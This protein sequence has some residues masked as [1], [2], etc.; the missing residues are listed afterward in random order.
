MFK[1]LLI[2]IVALAVLGGGIVGFN[3]FR[4]RMIAQYF[5][6]MKPAPLPVTVAAVAPAPWTPGIDTIG[7]ANAIRGADLSTEASGVVREIRFNAN[8]SVTEGQ[9][10]VQIDDRQERADLD[11][12]KASLNLAQIT[13]ARAQSLQQRGVSS[14][15]NLDSAQAEEISAEA[16][17]AKLEAVLQTK[18][19]LAPFNG[20]VGIPRVEV[21]EYVSPGTVYATLQDRSRMRADFTLTEQQAAEVSLGS[22]LTATAEDG[23]APISGTV[24]GIDP[25][26]DP[27]SRL[28]T[29]RATLDTDGDALTPGQFL[30]LRIALPTE[31]GV[32]ALPQTVVASSLYGDTVYVLREETPQGASAPETVVRQVFVTLGRRFGDKVEIRDGLK[33][34]DRV[35]TAGLNK[36]SP[37][38]AVTVVDDP[39]KTGTAPA[40]N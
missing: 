11:S 17:V 21:G 16:A 6:T 13:L 19:L 3:L 10:L 31:Q 36:L 27:N 29:L 14:V 9:L 22:P 18:Q 15:S 39:A 2:A 38:A 7:T 35:V 24:T 25:K 37:G 34:G 28:V 33:A 32:I 4:A 30:R 8:D 12:A 20:T 40:A 1:R 5:A 26:I 23:S